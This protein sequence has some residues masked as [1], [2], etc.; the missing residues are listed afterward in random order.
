[1]FNATGW[2]AAYDQ[3]PRQAALL[4]IKDIN[5]Q[6][7]V[8]GRE[9]QL[10]ELDGMTDPPAVESAARQLVEQG[11]QILI[12]PCDFDVGAPV[13]LVA[14][15]A[16][17]VGISTCATSPLY[18]SLTLG[19]KQFTVGMWGN[20]MGAAM[21]DYGYKELGWRTAYVIVETTIDYSSSLGRYFGEHFESLGGTIVGEDAYTTGEEDFSAHIERIQALPEEPDVLYISGIMP[22]LGFILHQV[23][24]AGIETPIAGGDTYDDSSLFDILGPE[25]GNELY[26]AT[27]SWLGPE[28]GWEMTRFMDL[29]TAEYGEPPAS[30][31][32]VM[33]WDTVQVLVH[34]IGTT[35]TTDGAALAEA[36]E[37]IQFDLL[38][39]NLRWTTAAEG[40][41]PE[42]AAAI[43]AVQGGE[44]AFLSWS[45]P[46]T[47]PEP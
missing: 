3:P 31:F 10:V 41:Q 32:I 44:P 25:L 38:S 33:G 42:K 8:L 12:A 20:T 28:A 4:A 24:E 16:G 39:G 5:A 13:S 18:S 11:A 7:G 22:D 47:L 29:Y 26:M 9:L 2:M 6:G 30:S 45:Q 17:M 23:R 19:D 1:V 46:E 35:G 27:H 40:H 43:V 15:E 21:A 36:M 37:R 14:Q 34:A